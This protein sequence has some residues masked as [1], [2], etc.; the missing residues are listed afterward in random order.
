[1]VLLATS[2]RDLQHALGQ[3][4]AECEVVRMRVSTSKS[5]AMV[6]C[7]KT[8]E[9]SLG[10]GMDWCSVCS[11]A[12][13]VPVRSGEEGAEQ[14]GETLDLPVHLCSNPHL[15]SQALGSDRKNEIAD[16]SGQNEFPPQGGW[17]QPQR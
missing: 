1:V 2:D 5:E 15:W 14:E 7:Q 9:Y 17:A 16:T 8:V 4:A 12:G 13:T 6:L 11:N 10:V 3:F